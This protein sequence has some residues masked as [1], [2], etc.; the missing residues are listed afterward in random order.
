MQKQLSAYDQLEQFFQRSDIKIDEYQ[1]A[2]SNQIVLFACSNLD[3]NK[4]FIQFQ[5]N[6]I[7]T[8][9]ATV[10]IPN[11][12]IFPFKDLQS[13]EIVQKF[14]QN[15]DI[16][17]YSFMHSYD[18]IS[19]SY[20]EFCEL[21]AITYN[22]YTIIIGNDQDVN[23]WNPPNKERF[24]EVVYTF[25][26]ILSRLNRALQNFKKDLI[27]RSLIGMFNYKSIQWLGIVE[28][29]GSE[30]LL[31]PDIVKNFLQKYNLEFVFVKCYQGVN[32][33]SIQQI[34]QEIRNQLIFDF[35]D[36]NIGSTLYFWSSKQFLGSYF[37]PHKHY[38]ILD[39]VKKM[40]K[41][42]KF[43][44]QQQSPYSFLSDYD[45]NSS[46]IEFY[47]KY[48]NRILRDNSSGYTFSTLTSIIF[49]AILIGQENQHNKFEQRYPLSF[50]MKPTSIVIIPLG[51]NISGLGF[52]NLFQSLQQIFSFVK[53]IKSVNQIT[54]TRQIYYFDQCFCFDQCQ[55]LI[56]HLN[57]IKNLKI[58]GL[59]HQNNQQSYKLQSG[60]SLPFS[61]DY[62]SYS[63]IES[64]KTYDNFENSI[65]ILLSYL[66]QDIKQLPLNEL[67][68]ISIIPE[69]Q[70]QGKIKI[71]CQEQDIYEIIYNKNLNIEQMRN[72]FLQLRQN[73]SSVNDQN[74]QVQVQNQY[75]YKQSLKLIADIEAQLRIFLQNPKTSR[76]YVIITNQYN[77]QQCEKQKSSECIITN[78]SWKEI[79]DYVL[80]SL[81][82]IKEIYRQNEIISQTFKI[83]DSQF[84]HAGQVV[85][86]SN[87]IP[88]KVLN[89]KISSVKM[90]IFVIV[91]NAMIIILPQDLQL[92]SGITIYTKQLEASCMDDILKILKENIEKLQQE[93]IEE[94]SVVNQQFNFNNQD[95]NAYIVKYSSAEI[96]LQNIK[97][98]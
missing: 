2:F 85:Y 91:L 18:T 27:N 97:Q 76:S 51:F 60:E 6:P 32:L 42:R 30:K 16:I 98:E 69:D 80:D 49:N 61:F 11:A 28:H 36:M 9:I 13:Q 88:F 84:L 70:K 43:I 39:T 54:N 12:R 29:Y 58:V 53:K 37:I 95:W 50:C 94:R 8:E 41:E 64:S 26:G 71:L 44:N 33:N 93:N 62:I 68:Q 52:D 14:Q 34:Y 23:K 92:F 7:Q 67:L 57:K 46:E 40:F 1:S 63:L 3:Q 17:L 83:L 24:F 55:N 86:K 5:M 56:N 73:N 90:Q 66:D 21:F 15:S 20:L 89:N 87:K 35:N 81:E 45:L 19:V 78:Q 38:E 79:E 82:L 22:G 75:F 25:F 59:L 10:N 47:K 48:I 65:N 31:Q 74:F 4:T 72:H 96:N 77:Q